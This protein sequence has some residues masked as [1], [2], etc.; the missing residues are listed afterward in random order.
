M[1]ISQASAYALHALMYMV[2]HMTQLPVTGKAIAMSEGIPAG[3]LAKVMQQ[4]VR[5]G[6]VRSVRGRRRGYVFARAPE[7]IS[8]L[9]LFEALEG[10]P[11][12]DECPLKHCNCGGTSENCRIFSRWTSAVASFREILEEVTVSVAAWTHPEHRFHVLP[13]VAV[14]GSGPDGHGLSQAGSG[15]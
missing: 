3:Y 8:L 5:A 12:L 14:D 7:E 11:L 4:L 15:G 9:E 1:K 6:F 2:R 13:D 10:R